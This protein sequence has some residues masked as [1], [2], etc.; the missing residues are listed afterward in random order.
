MPLPTSGTVLVSLKNKDK[1]PALFMVK[2]LQDL[3]FKIV[4]T[5]GTAWFLKRQ[6]VDAAS[7]FKVLEGRPNVV[8]LLKNREVQLVVNTPSGKRCR[9]D[10]IAIRT[11][12]IACNVSLI[13]TLQGFAA[14][15]QGIEALIKEGLKVKPIQEY[16]GEI[17]SASA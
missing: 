14:A 10:E 13:T 16:H 3:G 9:Q 17:R 6:G 5:G 8:D 7:V 11:T 1:R 4:A 15:V 12:A 2:K